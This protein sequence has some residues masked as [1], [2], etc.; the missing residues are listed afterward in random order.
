M[1]V[2]FGRC[3]N[4]E[5]QYTNKLYLLKVTQIVVIAPQTQPPKKLPT[6]LEK[7]AGRGRR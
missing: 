3:G 2:E 1:W 6:R 5:G 4:I 7:Q